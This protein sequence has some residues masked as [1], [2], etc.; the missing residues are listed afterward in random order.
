MLLCKVSVQVGVQ[1]NSWT[2]QQKKKGLKPALKVDCAPL[3]PQYILSD[4]L[5]IQLTYNE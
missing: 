2:L 1:A 4:S 3:F 5:S